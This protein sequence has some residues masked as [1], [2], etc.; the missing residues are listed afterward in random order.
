M[1]ST[2]PKFIIHAEINKF[3][4]FFQ[5]KICNNQFCGYIYVYRTINS[6]LVKLQLPNSRCENKT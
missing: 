2:K 3:F 6:H 4:R 5:K 1:F